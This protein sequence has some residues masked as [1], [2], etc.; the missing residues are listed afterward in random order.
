[1][2]ENQIGLIKQR[3]LS[4]YISPILI[5]VIILSAAL[6]IPTITEA[7]KYSETLNVNIEE[8]S[9]WL[10]SYDPDYK[11]K[12]VFSDIWPYSSWFLQMNV[13]KM[14]QFKNNKKHYLSLKNYSPTK[15]DSDFANQ[16]LVENN[17]YYYFS[18]RDWVDLNDY[19]PINKFGYVTVYKKTGLNK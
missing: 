18:I 14:P 5:L 4:L 10:K 16:F 9:Y 15:E 3:K 11:S 1:M 13:Q 19:D 12:I 6:Y 2:V 7:N 17:A 8:A